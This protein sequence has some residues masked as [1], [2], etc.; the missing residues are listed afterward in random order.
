LATTCP[1][2]RFENPDDTFF[3]GKCATPLPATPGKNSEALT[4]TI[5]EIG[6][7]LSNGTLIATKY[8]ILAKLGAGGMGEVY[9]AEDLS[10]NRQVAIKVLPEVFASDQERLARFQREAKVLASLNHPDIAAI[11]GVEEA[12]GKHFLVLEL[13]EGETLAERLSRDALSLEETLE[14]CR[15]I[16]EGLEGAHEKGIIHRDLKPANVKITPEGKV[17]I[18]DFGLAKALVEGTTA[19]DIANSPTITANMTQP[20]VILG[21]A[22]YMS[23]EQAT[24]KQV[25]KRADIWAFG[26]ILYEC[27]TGKRAFSGDTV[28]ETIAAILKGEP[29]WDLL[30]ADTPGSVRAVLRRSLQKDPR[31]RLRDIAD[32]RIDMN[33]PIFEMPIPEPAK[34][35]PAAPWISALIGAA[36]I[37]GVLLGLVMMKLLHF[38]HSPP[39]PLVKATIKLETGLWLDG[40]RSYFDL[41]RPSRTAMAVS[42]DGKF[43]VYCASEPGPQA[44]PK[45]F[46]RRIGE[47]EAKPIGGTEGGVNPFLSP[48]DKWVGF[49]SDRKLMKVP[50]DGGV[51]AELCDALDMISGASWGP[52]NSI[53][54]CPGTRS[55]INRVS[56]DG[57]K[58]EALTK[59]S[60]ERGEWGHHLPVY[61]PDGNGVLFTVVEHGWDPR[62]DVAVLD[63]KTGK[64]KALVEDAADA[65]YVP[66]GHLVFLRRGTLMAVPF[67]LHNLILIGQPVPVIENVMHS[68]FSLAGTRNTDAGQFS[69][70]GSGSLLFATGGPLPPSEDSLEW[71]DMKG[72]TQPVTSLKL[73]F[74]GPRLS[75]EG[76]RI[77]YN[78]WGESAQ[79]RVYDLI[80]GTNS[81]LTTE[82]FGSP[83]LWTGDGKRIFFSVIQS[84]RSKLFWRPADGSAPMELLLESDDAISPQSLS[85]EGEILTTCKSNPESGTDIFLFHV[86][87]R[88]LTPFLNSQ[89]FEGFPEFSPDGH[90]IAYSS[91]ESGRPEVYVTRFPGPQ[92]KWQVSSEGGTESVWARDGR[93]LFFRRKD[94][95]WAVDIRTDGDFQHG[96]PR[97]LFEQPGFVTGNPIRSFDLSQDGKRFLMAKF[98]TR[99]STPVTEMVLVQNWFEELKRLVPA[100]KK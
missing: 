31:E 72:L 38:Q 47:L 55:G 60:I 86:R 20:G 14:I 45:L 93:Q 25:D 69:I 100:G 36:L 4:K 64:W 19:M 26:C 68:L 50:I 16:T 73:P 92:G 27:L 23:P 28:T 77:T 42:N 99:T 70:S 59:P 10:L 33:E 39:L 6:R 24:G 89:Y 88:R 17:K 65:R 22:A 37:A 61:L 94:Q 85:P 74:W 97:L 96:K 54:F 8:R 95:V 66:T 83:A 12:D 35:R 78:T 52:D 58:P 5:G 67:D 79:I 11:Y 2:C 13:V 98:G 46:L 91:D 34:R 1:K 82:G 18:L 63:I 41:Q 21:T 81:R 3:C 75:P 57:G 53:V 71:V 29:N 48:N 32:A 51:P 7:D 76:G 44:K 9:R 49:W 90:W 30:P 56:A 87:E 40:M 84:A 80:L 62:P 43:L 15:Q